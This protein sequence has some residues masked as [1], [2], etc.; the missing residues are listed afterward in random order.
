MVSNV[1]PFSIAIVDEADTAT[2]ALDSRV[3]A[4]E[5]GVSRMDAERVTTV[6]A[7]LASNIVKYAGRGRITLRLVHRQGRACVEVEAR[8]RGPGIESVEEALQ[9]HYSTSGTLGL[10]LPG[11]QRLMDV[12]EIESVVGE[13]T[14]VRAYKWLA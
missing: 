7:E 2:A 11:V 1:K 8:D 5:A 6:V 3:F 12:V 13:G 4:R 14:V 10:G 9:E